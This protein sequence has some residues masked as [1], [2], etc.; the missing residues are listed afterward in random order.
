MMPIIGEF[1]NTGYLDKNKNFIYDKDILL[2][3][4]GLGI[5]ILGVEVA[6]HQHNTEYYACCFNK[7]TY[8]KF[9]LSDLNQKDIE[10]VDFM[11]N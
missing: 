3:K 9:L 5:C 8:L 6:P 1:K 10:I 4:T 7:G 2:Y 11:L